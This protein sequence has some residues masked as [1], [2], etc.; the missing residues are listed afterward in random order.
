MVLEAWQPR[1][2]HEDTGHMLGMAEQ[3]PGEA[4][5]PDHFLEKIHELNWPPRDFLPCEEKTQS[6]F[7]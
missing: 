4:Q 2:D 1:W 3:Q 7:G 6:L 5:V